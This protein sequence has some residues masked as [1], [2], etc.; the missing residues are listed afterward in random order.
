MANVNTDD[1][2]KTKP[3][4]LVQIRG[5]MDGNSWSKGHVCM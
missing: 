1:A 2:F 3:A 5:S 4:V